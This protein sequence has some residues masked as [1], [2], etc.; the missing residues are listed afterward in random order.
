MSNHLGFEPTSKPN[1]Y[2]VSY[3]NED[4]ERVGMIAGNLA[5]SNVP[6]WYDYGIEYGEGWESII[7]EKLQNSQAMILFFT[8]GILTKENS[9]VRKEYKMA[10]EFFDKKVYVVMM[11]EIANK[12]V[13][14]EKVPWWIDIQE[15]QN[16]NIFNINDLSKI[17]EEILN[18]LGLATHEDKMNQIIMNYR[19]LYDLGK[20]EEAE[21]YLSEYLKGI[22]LSGKA[23]CVA[24]LFIQTPEIFHNSTNVSEITGLENPLIN[25]TGKTAHLYEGVQVTLSSDKYQIGNQSMFHRGNRGDA[26][27]ITIWKNGEYFYTIGGLIEAYRLTAY[28]DSIDDI[29][30]VIYESEKETNIDDGFDVTD[31]IGITTIEH[32]CD[33]AVCSDFK[34]LV[35]KNK[36]S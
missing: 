5:H 15:K 29:I 13:P 18:A 19:I 10:T 1:Y 4:V 8:K 24:N 21:S 35:P 31:Y 27:I 34:Y 33:D 7:S 23:I 17:S 25:H 32:P 9:Y 30:Y 11:D 20:T 22:S 26:H 12:D 3:N 28:Y 6:L 16:I 14:Y 2:F 36:K